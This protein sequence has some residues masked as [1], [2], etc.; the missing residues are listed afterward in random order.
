MWTL[1]S[2]ALSSSLTSWMLLLNH[3]RMLHLDR[4][5]QFDHWIRMFRYEGLLV[6]SSRSPELLVR[7]GSSPLC[8]KVAF[9]QVLCDLEALDS[10]DRARRTEEF[11]CVDVFYVCSVCSVYKSGVLERNREV[12]AWAICEVTG[13]KWLRCLEF[14]ACQ[15]WGVEIWRRQNCCWT[16]HGSPIR[17][18]SATLP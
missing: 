9:I 16:V 11:G 13:E 5:V 3:L 18:F 7:H 6:L 10:L 8:V 4:S 12:N 2:R 17:S 15:S 14:V 1:F